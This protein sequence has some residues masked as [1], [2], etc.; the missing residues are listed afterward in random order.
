MRHPRKFYA[1]NRKK[2][3]NFRAAKERKRLERAARPEPLP[4][5]SQVVPPKLKPSGFRVTIECLDDHERVS[6]TAHLTPWGRLSLS[7]TRAGRKVAA[8]LTHYAPAA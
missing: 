3:A 2:L 4:D 8:V 6:F 5:T 7:P 1:A